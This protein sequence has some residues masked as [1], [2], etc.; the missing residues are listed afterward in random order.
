MPNLT[1]KVAAL[2]VSAY[3]QADL[4]LF[5]SRLEVAPLVMYESFASRTPFITTDVGNVKDHQ[6]FLTI[7][8]TPSE[9]ATAAHALLDD[10]IARSRIAEKAFILCQK[11]Y[12]WNK[13]V[14]KYD[15]LIVN[16]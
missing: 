10:N 12:T 16:L 6:N 4:F 13:V 7:I 8:K 1:D 15:A 5:G 14:D 9:M 11:K 2:V 3:Q